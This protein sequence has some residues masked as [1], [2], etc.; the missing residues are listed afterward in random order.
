MTLA[1]NKMD[2]HGLG[3]RLFLAVHPDLYETSLLFPPLYP[4]H[5]LKHFCI[6]PR[7]GHRT[8]LWPLGHDL[9]GSNYLT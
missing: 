1:I 2:E 3:H 6:Y 5:S 4:V 8:V 7:F 9:S